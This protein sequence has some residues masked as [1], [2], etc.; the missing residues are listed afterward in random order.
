[1]SNNVFCNECNC[2]L[3]KEIKNC[4]KVIRNPA[5]PFKGSSGLIK[6]FVFLVP[7][8]GNWKKLIRECKFRGSEEIGF[9]FAESMAEILM[10]ISTN[11]EYKSFD[12]PAFLKNSVIV[13]PPSVPEKYENKP[14]STILASGISAK[15][16]INFIPDLFYKKSDIKQRSLK[17]KERV[18]NP[19]KNIF[20]KAENDLIEKIKSRNV[21]IIDDISTTLATIERTAYLLKKSGAL[22]IIAVTAGAAPEN[23]QS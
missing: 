13:V 19:W 9:F 20:L 3:K 2:F 12:G 7:Y 10:S 22:E 18:I 4:Y 14:M 16:K 5:L 21:I 17:R 15:I 23:R 1:M 8:S 6:F 11:R